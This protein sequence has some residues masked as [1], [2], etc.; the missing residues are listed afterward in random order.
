MDDTQSLKDLQIALAPPAFLPR[1]ELPN[2]EIFQFH[3][4]VHFSFGTTLRITNNRHW[5]FPWMVRCFLPDRIFLHTL[6][7]F[8][9][10]WRS[11]DEEVILSYHSNSSFNNFIL[12]I[13]I[14][15]QDHHSY[16]LACITYMFLS[17]SSAIATWSP[18][19][20]LS[21]NQ[22]NFILILWWKFI[23]IQWSR[24]YILIK[25]SK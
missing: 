5:K 6:L 8:Q 12:F 7:G 20:Y 19:R 21:S 4:G 13:F 16:N 18:L 10:F 25:W 23:T 17:D 9:R 2:K 11:F 14:Y 22:W 24:R 3:L 1:M 15:V